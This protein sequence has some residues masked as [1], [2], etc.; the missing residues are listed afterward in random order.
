MS[1]VDFNYFH[2][3][4][5]WGELKDLSW[6]EDNYYNSM[7]NPTSHVHLL[8]YWYPDYYKT[9][10]Y[11]LF[12]FFSSQVAAETLLYSDVNNMNEFCRHG[13]RRKATSYCFHEPER[14]LILAKNAGPITFSGSDL[15]L[16]N[17]FTLLFSC[18][19][20]GVSTLS[21]ATLEP[22]LELGN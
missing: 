3:F 17:I 22:F 20:D 1:S 5:M 19:V 21:S 6:L 18:R 13:N 8:S 16:G 2:S 15:L 7:I 12:E 9:G 14:S 11:G 4:E 10:A